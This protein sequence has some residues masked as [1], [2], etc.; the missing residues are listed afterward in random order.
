MKITPEDYQVLESVI[1]AKIRE[2]GIE[3]LSDYRAQLANDSKVTDVG[4][5]LRWDLLHATGYN[6][7]RL[8][9]Y[10]SDTH[11]DTALRNIVSNHLHA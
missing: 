9:S 1:A 3:R 8:Y 10:L 5:R 4:V 7:S 2:T 11:I 6:T